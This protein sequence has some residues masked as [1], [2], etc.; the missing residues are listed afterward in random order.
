MTGSEDGGSV[1]SAA[2]VDRIVVEDN[3]EVEDT[4]DVEE[5]KDEL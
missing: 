4:E 2:S 3:S 5:V 1:L